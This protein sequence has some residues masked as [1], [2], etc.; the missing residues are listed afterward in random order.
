MLPARLP[1]SQDTRRNQKAVRLI[2]SLLGKAGGPLRHCEITE[3]VMHVRGLNL[4][5]RALC[6]TLRNRIGASLRGMRDRGWLVSGE[7]KGTGVRWG[8]N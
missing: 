6:L 2:P 4:A 1:P 5:G 8:L 3:R 7:G